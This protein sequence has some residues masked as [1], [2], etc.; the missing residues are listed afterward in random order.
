MAFG[1][2]A[3]GVDI[4][5]LNCIPHEVGL[6]IRQVIEVESSAGWVPFV[7]ENGGV[8]EIPV[9]IEK[10]NIYASVFENYG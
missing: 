6:L 5:K 7:E 2:V 4:I 3:Y 9:V 10:G 1:D 8:F